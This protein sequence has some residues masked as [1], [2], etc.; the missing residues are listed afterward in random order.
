MSKLTGSLKVEFSKSA[1]VGTLYFSEM[2]D[3][4][5]LT[6]LGVFEIPF[7]FGKCVLWVSIVLKKLVKP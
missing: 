2:A 6:I 1:T 3:G 7:S 4:N 5:F